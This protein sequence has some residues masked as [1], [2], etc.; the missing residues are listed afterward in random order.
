[1]V[2]A[3]C[4]RPAPDLPPDYGSVDAVVRS[5]LTDFD[6][7]D[8]ELTCPEIDGKRRMLREEAERLTARIAHRHSGNQAAGYVGAV[9]FAPALLALNLSE[10]EKNKLNTLQARDDTLIRLKSVKLCERAD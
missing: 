3:G 5:N 9:L 7:E 6:P 4:N 10:E 8:R 2:P 1:M